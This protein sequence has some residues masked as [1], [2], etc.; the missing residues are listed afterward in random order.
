MHA[1]IACLAAIGAAIS[2]S[3]PNETYA[4][5]EARQVAISAN[6]G[7]V[8]YDE[9]Q[10]SYPNF[11]LILRN[12]SDRELKVKELRGI[13]TAA[14]EMVERRMI[15]QQS[16]AQL[17]PDRAVAP[18]GQALIFNPFLFRSATLGSRI[19]YEVEF[20]GDPQGA[21]PASTTISLQ[22]CRNRVRLVLPVKGRVLVYDGYDVYSHHRLTGYGGPDDATM[23]ISDNFQRFGL[24]LVVVD[25]N[26]RF[27]SGDGS[28]TDQWFGWSMPVRAAGAGTVAAVHDGQPDNVVIGTVDRWV[29]RDMAR[30]P[31]SSYGNYVL[32]DHGGGEF[33]LVAH[34]RD[35]SVKVRN[36]E[37]V[38]EGQAVGQIGNSG[39]SGG[40]HV[41]YERRTG[42]GI[43]GIQTL[44][45]Y[46]D[47]LYL[48]NGG[49]SGGPIPINSGDVVTAR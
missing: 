14:G 23:G 21:P 24:D 15:W 43:A 40:V 8:C 9:S 3:F 48:A 17:S 20:E 4:A 1:R 42:H 39:A 2:S 22:D 18:R 36:G 44:P 13:V 30:N 41:H 34:L 38:R 29:D 6:P 35:G 46:F 37:R 5:V 10:P 27:H 11:D 31:M 47:D 49:R 28:R 7:R 16:V 45:P 12:A 32:I 25:E 26:G 33:S 19:R